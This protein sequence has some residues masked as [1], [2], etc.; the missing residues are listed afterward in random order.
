MRNISWVTTASDL[1][2][3]TLE[4][5]ALLPTLGCELDDCG[6]HFMIYTYI[7]SLCCTPETNNVTCRLYLNLKKRE[8]SD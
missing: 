3:V 2:K 4:S 5:G 7:E 6:D 1:S 8:T